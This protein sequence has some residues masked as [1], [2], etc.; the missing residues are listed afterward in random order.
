MDRVT[1]LGRWAVLRRWAGGPCYI[2]E[3]VGRVTSLGRWT[4][5]HR[6]A[7]GPCFDGVGIGSAD[8]AA[9]ADESTFIP[10]AMLG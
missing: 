6:W 3:Q 2:V 10:V 1:S 9:V 5:L 4:M 8:A 7:G